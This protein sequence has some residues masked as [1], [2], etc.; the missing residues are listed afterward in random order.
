MVRRLLTYTAFGFAGFLVASYIFI[1]K[2]YRTEYIQ[3]GSERWY[4]LIKDGRFPAPLEL[5]YS[6][7]KSNGHVL[8]ITGTIKN[9]REQQASMTVIA[10][11]LFDK[12]GKFY[13]KCTGVLPVIRPKSEYN[14]TFHCA[15]IKDIRFQDHDKVKIYVDA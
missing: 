8:D 12:S 9:P 4:Q 1:V 2:G 5:T 14:F 3:P 13:H 11:D 10:A 15:N 6:E 7:M